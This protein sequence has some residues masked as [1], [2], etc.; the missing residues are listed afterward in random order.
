LTGFGMYAKQQYNGG[1]HK[2]FHFNFV[3]V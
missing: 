3:S 2:M 1:D